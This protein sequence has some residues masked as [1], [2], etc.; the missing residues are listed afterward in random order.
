M[1]GDMHYREAERLTALAMDSFNNP[2]GGYDD[3]DGDPSAEELAI[4]SSILAEA[5]RDAHV[6]LAA[7]QIHAT[8]ALAGATALATTS[9]YIGDSHEITYWGQIVQPDAFFGKPCT[10]GC[11]DKGRNGCPPR[12]VAAQAAY[13][14]ALTPAELECPF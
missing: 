4:R 2:E 5:R 12:C 11:V 14:A 13:V 3:S 9:R 8:L 1:N 10:D 7:A 6:Y